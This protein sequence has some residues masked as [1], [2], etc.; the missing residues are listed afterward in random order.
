MA[1][2]VKKM[3]TPTQK[4]RADRLSASNTELTKLFEQVKKQRDAAESRLQML[5]GDFLRL[6][7]AYAALNHQDR[8]ECA[9]LEIKIQMM[10]KLGVEKLRL[11]DGTEI[12]LGDFP[13]AIYEATTP[14][15]QRLEQEGLPPVGGEP[16]HEEL[17][18]ASSPLG[19]PP[20]DARP[21]PCVAC[22]G[23]QGP[24]QTGHVMCYGCGDWQL[25]PESARGRYP[26]RAPVEPTT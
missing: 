7:E 5:R 24:D 18:Y 23:E 1:T 12:V 3:R 20:K 10:R 19:P 22:G 15:P 26:E 25:M 9:G 16:T 11:Q 2:R 17:L 6:Q 14:E 13:P 8:I 21:P 4:E